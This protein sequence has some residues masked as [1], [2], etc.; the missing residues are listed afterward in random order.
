MK[1]SSIPFTYHWIMKKAIG[2]PKTLLDLGCGSGD[3]S[4][5]LFNSDNFQITGVELYP[6]SI[7]LAKSKNIYSKIIKGDIVKLP[8]GLKKNY[9]V[10]LVSQAIEHLTKKKGYKAIQEWEKRAKKVVI[11]TPVGFVPFH[12]LELSEQDQNPYQKHLSGW[13]VRDFEKMGY[14]VY[15]QGW[16]FLYRNPFVKRI[17]GVFFPLIN[18]LSFLLSPIVYILPQIAMYQIAVKEIR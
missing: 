2:S 7:K 8:I 18:G 16:G 5:D 6:E 9:D 15:G 3:F 10:V 13:E 4:Y 1:L 14:K 11:S 17:P 12:Q